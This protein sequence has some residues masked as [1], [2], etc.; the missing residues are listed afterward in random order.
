MLYK[1]FRLIFLLAL[2]AGLLS[3]ESLPRNAQAQALPEQLRAEVNLPAMQT[4]SVFAQ[5]VDPNVKLI[6]SAWRSP[7]GSD[8]DQY[9]WDNFTL[10]ADATITEVH[11]FGTYDP[12]RFGAGGPV[13]DFTVRIFP[14]TVSGLEPAVANPPLVQYQTGGNAGETSSG[15]VAGATLYDYQFKLPTP[16]AASAGV[17][18]WVQIEAFQQGSQPDWCLVTGTGGDGN[19]FRKTSGAG[20]DSLYRAYP[21]DVVFYLQGLVADQLTP[22]PVIT[23]TFAPNEAPTLTPTNTTTPTPTPLP[24]TP[25]CFGAALALVL[26]LFLFRLPQR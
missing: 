18:Y 23:A 10:P 19:H 11:W 4:G 2:V 13:L 21:G 24:Q 12:M 14:S 8:N 16:F 22:T 20:G 7:D 5:P 9:V 15:A 1:S 26:G 25:T 3:I 17:K 6:L